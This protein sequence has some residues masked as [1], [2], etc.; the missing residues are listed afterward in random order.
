MAATHSSCALRVSI[1]TLGSSP[2][3]AADEHT[4]ELGMCV[5]EALEAPERLQIRLRESQTKPALNFRQLRKSNTTL[6]LGN[7]K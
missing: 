4:A 7:T 2:N 3:A 6:V 5:M 1:N